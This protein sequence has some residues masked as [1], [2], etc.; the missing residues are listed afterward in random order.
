MLLEYKDKNTYLHRLDIR[1]KGLYFFILTAA[2]F[3]FP[4]PIYN[5]GL[6]I[7][8]VLVAVSV[9]M[10]F[11]RVWSTLKP[12][13]PILVIIV[14]VTAMSYPPG[15]FMLPSSK[16]VVF[17]LF[18]D[19]IEATRGGFLYGT[20]LSLRILLIVIASTVLTYTSP[21][22]HFLQL[23]R[24]MRIPYKFAFIVATGI[25]FIPTME[26]KSRQI[27]DAQRIRGADFNSG[28]AVSRIR[29]FLPIM[30]PMIVSSI[31]MS[32]NLAMS[33]V[34]RGFGSKPEVT[35]VDELHAHGVD[36]IFSILGL[37]L[38]AL[39]IYART[40]GNGII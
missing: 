20:S 11:G 14:G 19:T 4:D 30:V 15:K 33:M 17:S 38:L 10:P 13:I 18:S 23:L 24:K 25:R 8:I 9:G 29:A 21:I 2:A 27:I 26:K 12:L 5:V 37:L 31:R 39:V 6:L 16:I 40:M 22:D 28:G 3:M 32:E 35:E 7:L 1:T 36:Y 34:N